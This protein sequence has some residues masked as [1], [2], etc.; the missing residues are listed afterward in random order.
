MRPISLR[1]QRSSP[2]LHSSAGTI[3]F[4]L[5]RFP[6]RWRTGSGRKTESPFAMPSLSRPSSS[7][8]VRTCH[9]SR[10]LSIESHFSWRAYA[11]RGRQVHRATGGIP[12]LVQ[13]T[14]S[15]RRHLVRR[16]SFTGRGA[17]PSRT[18]FLKCARL[19]PSSEL[20]LARANESIRG[21][22]T[23]PPLDLEAGSLVHAAPASFFPDVS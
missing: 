5:S 4:P 9:L 11:G 7:L 22:E 3:G 1:S 13:S 18:R 15:R 21:I 12:A 8:S 6:W 10:I 17:M 16:P 14:I 19:Q 23:S 2:A 20:A